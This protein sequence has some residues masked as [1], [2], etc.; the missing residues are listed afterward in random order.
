MVGYELQAE[1]LSD[2]TPEEAAKKLREQAVMH[3]NQ[4]S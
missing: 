1:A 3:Y 2:L 4:T